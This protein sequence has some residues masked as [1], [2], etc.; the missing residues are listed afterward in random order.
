MHSNLIYDNTYSDVLLIEPDVLIQGL[1]HLHVEPA[2][3]QEHTIENP[4]N[5]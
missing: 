4:I 2:E 1:Q 3:L 5:H